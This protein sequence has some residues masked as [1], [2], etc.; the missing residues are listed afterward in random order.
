MSPNCKKN[1]NLKKNTLCWG[2]SRA[3]S[4]RGSPEHQGFMEKGPMSLFGLPMT[5]SPA[6]PG[7]TGAELTVSADFVTQ[8]SHPVALGGYV[9]YA[10]E[11]RF[12]HGVGDTW[13]GD[14]HPSVVDNGDSL[15]LSVSNLCL[16]YTPIGASR[17][18][19]GAETHGSLLPPCGH[20]W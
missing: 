15:C 2:C 19:C 20:M 12:V 9:F 10:L 1:G 3:L 18:C 17:A 13:S 8:A 14:C 7:P 11:L 6:I 16:R 5:F 4:S